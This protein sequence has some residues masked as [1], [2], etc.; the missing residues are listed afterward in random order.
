MLVRSGRE[1]NLSSSSKH[2]SRR[3]RERCNERRESSLGGQDS[4]KIPKPISLIRQK[5]PRL[6]WHERRK[7][8]RERGGLDKRQGRKACTAKRTNRDGAWCFSPV[9][10]EHFYLFHLEIFREHS[11]R[12]EKTKKDFLWT[13]LPSFS[14]FLP[15]Q[16]LSLSLSPRLVSSHFLPRRRDSDRKGSARV[17]NNLHLDST[18]LD[19]GVAIFRVRLANSLVLER[20]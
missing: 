9:E 8:E 3:S 2:I 15:M 12:G 6:R 17:G 19:D 5:F 10:I 11:V 20:R 1:K 18:N 16:S 14:D 13:P 4:G 7:R